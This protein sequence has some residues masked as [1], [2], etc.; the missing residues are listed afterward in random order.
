MPPKV[1]YPPQFAPYKP[2]F[3]NTVLKII[4]FALNALRNLLALFGIMFIGILLL[5]YGQGQQIIRPFDE[6]FITLF[7]HFIQQALKK[8]IATALL[9]KIPLDKGVA[10]T[11]V[12]S[13]LRE[14]AQQLEF[15]LVNTHLIQDY[16][17][18]KIPHVEIFEFCGGDTLQTLIRHT[19]ELAV[20]LPCRIALYQDQHA[21][22]WLATLNMELLLSSTQKLPAATQQELLKIQD[23][24]LKIMGTGAGG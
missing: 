5:F 4:H 11:Q 24:L 16:R 7:G 8:D 10:P 2:S 13:S 3:Q 17:D 22:F 9:I 14:T 15:P 20:Y 23:N 12:N 18:G 1:E 19:P 21:Q 6:K